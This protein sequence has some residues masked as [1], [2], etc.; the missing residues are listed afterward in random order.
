MSTKLTEFA[1]IRKQREAQGLAPC[2]AHPRSQISKE[3][4]DVMGMDTGDEGCRLCGEVWWRESRARQS[5]D[6]DS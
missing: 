1:R 2:A 3:R 4:E 6:A 5:I